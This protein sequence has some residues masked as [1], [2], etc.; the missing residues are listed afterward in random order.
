M[1]DLPPGE[2]THLLVGQHWPSSQAILTTSHAATNR[3]TIAQATDEYA[4]LLHALS[5]GPLALQEGITAESIR[6]QFTRHEARQRDMSDSN[7]TKTHSYKSAYNRTTLFRSEL[8][9]IARQGNEAI[10]RI[11]HSDAPTDVKIAK[12]SSA[13]HDAQTRAN[14]KA[15]DCS[16]ALLSAIQDVLSTNGFPTSARE[17]ARANGLD[18]ENAFRSPSQSSS[19]EQATQFLDNATSTSPKDVR[20]QNQGTFRAGEL[21]PGSDAP[22]SRHPVQ[23]DQY[24]RAERNPGVT[25]NN[26]SSP[27]TRV[28][29][30]V[31][32][33]SGET[34]ISHTSMPTAT[35]TTISTSHSGNTLALPANGG[36][37]L[38]PT[39]S[40]LT[41]TSPPSPTSQ[42]SPDSLLQALTPT[43]A[44]LPIPSIAEA[45]SNASAEATPHHAA[46]NA[47][48]IAPLA[49]PTIPSPAPMFET[50]HA[51][52]PA[53]DAQPISHGP[54]IQPV[55]AAP[56]IIH[57]PIS[58]A[59]TITPS[60]LPGYGAD[61][62]PPTVA[63]TPPPPAVP[64][65]APTAPHA[66]GAHSHPAV[67]RQ[68]PAIPTS[69]VDRSV[70][71]EKAYAATATGAA[72]GKLSTDAMA[73]K[74]LQ[75][76]L[77][78]VARQEPKL[79][80]A[81]GDRNNGTTVLAT[82][83]AYGWI[84]PHIEIPTGLTL[85]QPTS[86]AV[87][88][89]AMLAG[90]TLQAIYE[91]GQRIQA[92][93]EPAPTSNRVRA[94]KPLDD[95][96][97]SLIQATKWRDGLPRL[98]HTLAKAATAKTGCLDS[99]V[100]LLREHLALAAKEALDKYPNTSPKA[101]G[102][103]Q[104][105]A[106]IEALLDRERTCA[107]YHLAWFESIQTRPNY[108]R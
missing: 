30:S 76:L 26:L 5:T 56:Q 16:A 40:G 9:E 14:A 1:S 63:P 47:A 58:P 72:A 11:R 64:T 23:N 34:A 107:N 6:N 7:T 95:L 52:S 3:A 69:S 54:S 96:A 84:P 4:N 66:T 31:A 101:A 81:I 45:L 85:I 43:H 53:V 17:F 51:A 77:A 99:E 42:T 41:L 50:A 59:P 79:R 89:E 98:A 78:A 29:S 10:Q 13:L 39:A 62:R 57:Q 86:E 46:P 61:A 55:T 68:Q 18:L 104:L 91:P 38:A 36:D 75:Q 37:N 82:D 80:W 20:P 71:D 19:R 24:S 65:S 102:N 35:P 60:S 32:F 103:W 25:F 73:Q 33:N 8:E 2:W 88:L 105:L 92:P 90:T 87:S 83:I 100:H 108:D 94:T 44:G 93:H 22:A 74:R 28:A 21:P 67:V 48:P 97:W 27:G 106:A 15:A 70:T 49:A 12:I